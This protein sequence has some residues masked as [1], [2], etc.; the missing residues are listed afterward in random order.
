MGLAM[1]ADRRAAEVLADLLADPEPAAR[2]G[3]VRALAASGWVGAELLLRFKAR[4][5]DKEP[6]VL[7]D[8]FAGLL[9]LE[10]SS[11]LEP[12]GDG[13]RSPD[14][15]RFE[16]AAIALGSS[17]HPEALRLLVEAAERPAGWNRRKYLFRAIALIRGDEAAE[18]L[19]TVV[20]EA[21]EGVAMLVLEVLGDVGA[22]HRL[23]D[24][25]AEAVEARGDR[26]LSRA[27]RALR[28]D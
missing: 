3:A 5:G 24:R 12:V 2:S 25:L 23:R 28:P 18:Y 13:L 19:A 22:D 6:A 9:D 21:P 17:R 7:L 20:S 26:E 8:A 1:S 10:P 16:A 15:E 27:F 11:G 4:L 14:E